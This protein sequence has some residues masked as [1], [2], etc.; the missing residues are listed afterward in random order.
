MQCLSVLQLH[1]KHWNSHLFAH[2]SLSCDYPV[3]IVRRFAQIPDCQGSVILRVVLG[4]FAGSP[5][6]TVS[7]IYPL[8]HGTKV[9]SWALMEERLSSGSSV[10]KSTSCVSL[11][12]SLGNAQLLKKRKRQDYEQQHESLGTIEARVSLGVHF[13]TRN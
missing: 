3:Q 9:W 5:Q 12:C 13:N 8:L 2:I 10:Q 11:T 1:D 7:N 4:A 6:E